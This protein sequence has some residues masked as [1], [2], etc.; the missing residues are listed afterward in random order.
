MKE[1]YSRISCLVL[2]S[3][4]EGFPNVL[5]EAMLMQKVCIATR[6]GEAERI[7]ENQEWIYNPGD[8]ESLA[9]KIEV[10]FNLTIPQAEGIGKINR[11]R[12][13]DHYDIKN[14][15]HQFKLLIEKI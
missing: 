3:W 8:E 5:G 6:V 14:I 12:I 9:R 13:I 15:S 1:Q 4:D 2:P 10:F 7:L 11:Q